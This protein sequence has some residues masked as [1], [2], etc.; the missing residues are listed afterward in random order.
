MGAKR[1][2]HDSAFAG[3]TFLTERMIEEGRVEP[4]EKDEFH[5]LVY[6]VIKSSVEAYEVQRAREQRKSGPSRN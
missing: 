2:A 6:Q 3:A 5:T 1:L 4:E